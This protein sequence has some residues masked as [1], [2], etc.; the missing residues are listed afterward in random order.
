MKANLMKEV[1]S[2]ACAKR[3]F[4]QKFLYLCKGLIFAP[5]LFCENRGQE[6]DGRNVSDAS[7]TGDDIYPL[8]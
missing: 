1:V 5:F 7:L 3:G 2:L 6:K 8:F 4:F